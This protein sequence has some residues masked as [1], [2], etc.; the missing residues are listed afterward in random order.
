MIEERLIGEIMSREAEG[1]SQNAIH[2]ALNVSR[3]T[4]ARIIL[5]YEL[6]GQP[7]PPK[8]CVQGRPRICLQA[9]EDVSL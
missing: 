5:S 8:S 1:W 7:Y 6:F 2:K 4:V 3:P 9:Q